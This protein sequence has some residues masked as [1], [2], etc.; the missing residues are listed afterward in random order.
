MAEDEELWVATARFDHDHRQALARLEANDLI[1]FDESRSKLAFRHQTIFDV[2]RSR[3]FAARR[4]RLSKYVLDRQ[5]ALFVRPSLWS[6]LH[7]LRQ[8]DH[9]S[10]V[11]EF[12]TLWTSPSLRKHVRFLLLEYLGQLAEPD[13]TEASWFLPLLDDPE[14]RPRVLRAMQG[15]PGWFRRARSRFA[16][17]MTGNEPDAWRFSALLQRALDITPQEAVSAIELHWLASPNW[18]P[19]VLSAFFHFKEWD[20]RTA[21]LI[22]KI[23]RRSSR[24][25]ADI[26]EHVA[27]SI[28]TKDPGQA[29]RIVAARLWS[30]FEHAESTPS[31]SQPPPPDASETERTVYE[32]VHSDDA[33]KSVRDIVSESRSWHEFD[34]IVARDPRGFVE[35]IMPWVIH[36]AGKYAR[37]DRDYSRFYSHDLIFEMPG[38]EQYHRHTFTLTLVAAMKGFA[39]ADAGAFLAATGR[40]AGS[41]SMVVHQLIAAGLTALGK[42]HPCELLAYIL[43]DDRRLALGSHCDDKQSRVL[44]A[45]VT[46][47]LNPRDAQK[48]EE[49]ILGYA[50]YALDPSLDVQ[51][52]R[53]RRRWNRQ[54][55]ITLLKA[56]PLGLRSLRGER[57][58]EKES[59]S[60]PNMLAEEDLEIKVVLSP[61]SADQMKAAGDDD[62]LNLFTE[63]TDQKESREPFSLIGGS[64]EASRAFGEFAKLEPVRAKRIIARFVPGVQER[65]AGEGVRGL[66]ESKAIGPQ[67][68]L[69]LIA[70]LDSRGFCS[71]E[72]RQQ[73][74]WLLPNIALELGGLDDKWCEL[75]ESWLQDETSIHEIAT[76]DRTNKPRAFLGD[77]RGTHTLPHGNYPVLRTLFVGLCA[78]KPLAVDQWLSALERH[79]EARVES[80]DVWSALLFR[81]MFW[82]R[83]ADRGRAHALVEGVFA[84]YPELLR[85][86]WGIYFIGAN[87]QWLSTDFVHAC[88]FAWE[89]GSWNPG[90][91]AAAE[92]SMYRYTLFPEDKYCETVIERILTG[93]CNEPSKLASMRLGMAFSFGELWNHSATRD[94]ANAILIR[95]MPVA[96]GIA[97]EAVADVFR[98]CGLLPVDNATRS[99]LDAIVEYPMVL[100][101]AGGRFLVDRLKDLIADGNEPER[102]CKV[103]S[104]MVRTHAEPAVFQHK[105]SHAADGLVEIALTLQRLPDTR[106]GGVRLFEDLME[107]DVY[108]VSTTLRELDRRISDH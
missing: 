104:A 81:E 6:A 84:R 47:F 87:H 36:V 24:L 5:D 64:W 15:S 35:N 90:P 60:F 11:N 22:E 39:T 92:V 31:P 13:N 16:W 27:R 88:L 69:D 82:L 18:Y 61:M 74:S 98:L 37:R 21:G 49:R 100:R 29:V 54:H 20:S 1:V 3:V 108:S 72:Y 95:F 58:V 14:M 85:C 9:S 28:S 91:Q 73:I 93:E 7:Y 30:E 34:W 51:W 66:A 33:Y 48:L 89:S 42:T 96:E 44:I 62:M 77:Q 26:V 19:F 102:V 70:E 68:L 105:L 99:V 97:A 38:S 83:H 43:G 107:L 94:R 57:Y 45:A 59:R 17:L 67:G 76:H 55:R 40:W 65:P 79:L 25:H 71:P 52:R 4:T 56:F 53:E 32:I 41:D 80:P 103:A 10:Y 106:S 75:L 78:R 63:L 23:V 101:A 46:P 86:D 8:A 50:P 2:V 12:L